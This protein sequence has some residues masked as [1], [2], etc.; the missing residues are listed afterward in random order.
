METI[1]RI[2]EPYKKEIRKFLP[3]DLFPSYGFV[4]I[5][6]FLLI[7]ELFTGIKFID[8]FPIEV[9]EFLSDIFNQDIGGKIL[10]F[11]VF[12]LLYYIISEF[13][14]ALIHQLTKFKLNVGNGN[15]FGVGIQIRKCVL[16][17]FSILFVLF[18]ECLFDINNNI[19]N[20]LMEPNF[21]TRM[22]NFIFIF[23]TV[24]W[25]FN[26]II[27]LIISLY[28]V[29]TNVLNDNKKYRI[30]NLKKETVKEIINISGYLDHNENFE[31]RMKVVNQIKNEFEI[32]EKG[33]NLYEIMETLS[34]ERKSNNL[35]FS[36]YNTDLEE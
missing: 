23:T 35:Y 18:P 22:W 1:I 16:I 10:I 21:L 5:C 2:M 24:F 17:Y 3:D 7:F 4:A 9:Y 19:N 11:W 14:F 12:I 20:L 15:I 13:L 31:L 36:K 30:E 8:I 25:G 28:T 26:E 27:K 29:R 6:I 32:I 34:D 33:V